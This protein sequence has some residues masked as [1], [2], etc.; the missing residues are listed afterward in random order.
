[1]HNKPV[2]PGNTRLSHRIGPGLLLTSPP[3]RQTPSPPL[4]PLLQ[5][6]LFLRL[7]AALGLACAIPL[8]TSPAA[9]QTPQTQTFSN[10]QS[11]WNLIG[12]QVI[13]TNPDP[14]VV[15][16]SGSLAGVFESAWAFDPGQ[17]IWRRFVKLGLPK[18]IEENALLSLGPIEVGRG[19]W[20]RLSSAPTSAWQVLGNIPA[21]L[22]GLDL[23]Q[24]WNLLSFPIG[25]TTLP[26]GENPSILSLL[27]SSGANYDAIITWEQGYKK[28]LHFEAPDTATGNPGSGPAV[29]SVISDPPLPGFDIYRGYW[30]HLLDAALLRPRLL[31]S[32]RQDID[33]APLNNFP[34]WEDRRLSRSAI[35][36]NVPRKSDDQT[37]IV[38]QEGGLF[39]KLAFPILAVV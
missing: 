34:S 19:Y 11:G 13:P 35:R 29:P 15:F 33:A 30:V 18:T 12:F 5:P 20:V 1:M 21:N 3:H 25:A 2:S 31:T 8:S 26:A 38:F 17:H 14:A 9:A 37:D 24:G 7:A 36:P 27:A 10:L 39:S 6:S 23:K 22:P 32:V 28:L 16:G 4:T